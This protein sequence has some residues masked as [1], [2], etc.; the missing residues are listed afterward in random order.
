M[1]TPRHDAA[2]TPCDDD[3][4]ARLERAARAAGA[5]PLRLPSGAGH[6]A[7]SFRG[8]L[9]LAMLFVRCR[10]GISHNP[11]EFA[12]EEDIGLAARALRDFIL[13]LGS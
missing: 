10:G 4:S 5:A 7:M 11:A 9:P 6:D 12:A 3:L 1:F 2:A 8:V 13:D